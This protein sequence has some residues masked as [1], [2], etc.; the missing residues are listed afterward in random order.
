MFGWKPRRK[1]TSSSNYLSWFLLSFEVTQLNLECKQCQALWTS[2]QNEPTSPDCQEVENL[3]RQLSEEFSAEKFQQMKAQASSMCNENGL[4][5]WR[6]ALERGQEARQI[7]EDALARFEKDQVEGSGQ[8]AAPEVSSEDTCADG[9]SVKTEE[10][11]EILDSQSRGEVGLVNRTGNPSS[12]SPEGPLCGGLEKDVKESEEASLGTSLES[13]EP[14]IAEGLESLH[15]TAERSPSSPPDPASCSSTGQGPGAGD[16]LL[17]PKLPCMSV[18]AR[19]QRNRRKETTQYFQ[20]S[21]H[22]SFSSEDT[23]SQHSAEEA[24]GSS[25][26]LPVDLLG[27]KGVWAQEKATGIIYLENHSTS[28]LPNVATQ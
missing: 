28:P 11:E 14:E 10:R 27:P 19:G 20:L 24:L 22:E 17:S 2:R 13:R 15:M 26:A 18:P 3:L 12:L 9:Q 1:T 25:A 5:V 8:N 16:S 4:V 21:R 7:L 6:E 23:D